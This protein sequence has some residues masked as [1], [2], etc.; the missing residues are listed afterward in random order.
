MWFYFW[1]AWKKTMPV[2]PRKKTHQMNYKYVLKSR[3]KTRSSEQE[4]YGLH[5][6]CIIFYLVHFLVC[7]VAIIGWFYFVQQQHSHHHFMCQNVSSLRSC[8]CC[9]CYSYMLLFFGSWFL[10]CCGYPG[11]PR[12]LSVLLR[13]K[14]HHGKLNDSRDHSHNV[15][16]IEKKISWSIKRKNEK[17]NERRKRHT[18]LLV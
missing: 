16:R 10:F 9:C 5:W 11:A 12:D 15:I 2:V 1:L 8:C 4:I 18:T 14:T 7:S 3:K 6:D 13:R 17:K